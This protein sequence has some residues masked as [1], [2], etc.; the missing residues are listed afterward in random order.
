MLAVDNNPGMYDRSVAAAENKRV[1]EEK[2]VCARRTV[3][4]CRWPG[5]WRG[6]RRA[7]LTWGGR[8]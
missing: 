6:A 8:R 7:R 5:W 3:R 1:D 2:S 4:G